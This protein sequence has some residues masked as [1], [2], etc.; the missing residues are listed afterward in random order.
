MASTDCLF[1]LVD[2]L[3]N[4]ESTV[5]SLIF[6]MAFKLSALSSTNI[7]VLVENNQ[8]RKYAGKSHLCDFYATSGLK[9]LAND[10]RVDFDSSGVMTETPHPLQSTHQLLRPSQ[11]SPSNL[12]ADN[13][14]PS[15]VKK[16]RQNLKRWSDPHSSPLLNG[17]SNCPPT[18]DGHVEA[19]LEPDLPQ[20]VTC[21]LSEETFGHHTLSSSSDLVVAKFEPSTLNDGDDDVLIDDF[22]DP[23]DEIRGH[24]VDG[25]LDSVVSVSSYAATSTEDSGEVDDNVDAYLALNGKVGA[26]RKMS[27]EVSGADV[28]AFTPAF[29]I[30]TSVLYDVAKL[31]ANSAPSNDKRHP[32]SR[33]HFERH[34][35]RIMQEFP[36]LRTLT[37]QGVKVKS[38]GFGS[39]V[40][41]T[42]QKTF[43]KLLDKALNSNLP[44]SSIVPGPCTVSGLNKSLEMSSLDR[45][46]LSS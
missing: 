17:S 15:P 1:D 33:A 2:Q 22:F 5:T 44:P 21:T 29:K 43:G 24:D 11:P 40:R 3:H 32:R 9:S 42:M 8:G 28:N 46:P 27:L 25:R 13:L 45:L 34:F 20:H 16:R 30:M 35:D 37:D 26:F 12:A 19:T 38:S 6:E 41:S 18:I 10:V 7:F 23:P 14:G 4:L 36:Q 31:A 39:F